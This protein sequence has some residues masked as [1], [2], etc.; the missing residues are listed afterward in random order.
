MTEAAAPQPITRHP[1]LGLT[2]LVTA[3]SL[4]GIGLSIMTVGYPALGEAFPGVS[5]PTLSWV[6]NIFTI[7][8][9]ATLVPAGALAD[10]LGRRRMLL[11]G[12]SLFLAGSVLGG[13]APSVGV[14]IGARAVLAVASS[15]INTA[16]VAL[17]LATMA[18]NRLPLAI[19]IWAVAGGTSSA[20]GPPVGGLMI[21][22]FGWEWMFWLNLP[23]CLFVLV[24]VPLVYG[25]SRRAE[26]RALPD[27]AGGAMV[28]AAT[29]LVTLGIV[30]SDPWGWLDWKVTGS[31]TAGLL[32]FGAFVRRSW[33]HPNPLVEL[34]MFRFPNVRRG[35]LAM[36]IF[37]SSWFGM[38]FGFTVIIIRSW[39]WTP[40]E[41][42]LA[43]APLALFAGVVG[44]LIGRVAHRTG[45]RVFI[46]PGT[47]LYACATMALWAVLG[48]EPDAVAFVVG[49]AVI[50]VAT[51]MVFPSLIAAAVHDVPPH[52][53]SL[54]TA[55]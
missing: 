17:L 50:G 24:T 16:A 39:G 52:Q 11:A 40:I 4:T 1:A 18:A 45:H 22:W 43:I 54:A 21:E 25:E 49:M 47:A 34:R 35:N 23:F 14:L 3:A 27:P 28:A 5:D 48:E 15:I 41:G 20:V 6:T 9:A 31:I 12:T 19:G 33:N 44:V 29:A 38:F 42:G 32:A 37:A 2:A 46:L 8:G 30:Q 51:G 26:N 55:I 13:M 53:Y 10:R 36:L 7:V